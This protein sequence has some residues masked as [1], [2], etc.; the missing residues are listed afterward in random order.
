MS[1]MAKISQQISPS[2]MMS[3]N[4]TKKL[5]KEDLTEEKHNNWRILGRNFLR[6][7]TRAS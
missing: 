7:P 4:E 6:G 1:Y 5:T 3:R 2:T